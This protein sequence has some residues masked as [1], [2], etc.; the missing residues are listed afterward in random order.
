MPHNP[1]GEDGSGSGLSVPRPSGSGPSPTPIGHLSG[2]K[3]EKGK[4]YYPPGGNGGDGVYA[5][6]VA[7]LPLQGVVAFKKN[8]GRKHDRPNR[9]PAGFQ[10]QP[11]IGVGEKNVVRGGVLLQ[12]LCRFLLVGEPICQ[13]LQGAAKPQTGNQMTARRMEKNEEQPRGEALR[14]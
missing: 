14:S 13:V 10:M 6:V 7:K 4:N 3:D 11:G 1:A 12:P 2:D 8:V 5:G 9:L